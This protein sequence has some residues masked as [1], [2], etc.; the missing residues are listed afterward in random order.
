MNT[1]SQTNIPVLNPVIEPCNGIYT[2]TTCIVN[3]LALTALSVPANS[4]LSDILVA[5]VAALN[6]QSLAIEDLVT[7]VENQT[8]QIEALQNQID[9]CCPTP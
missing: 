8:L 3:E 4:L 2:P 5:L 1:C 9:S 6:T 7:Q